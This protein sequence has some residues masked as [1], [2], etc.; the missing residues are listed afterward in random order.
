MIKYKIKLDND[1]LVELTAILKRSVDSLEPHPEEYM[2]INQSMKIVRS[3]LRDQVIPTF[4]RKL[5]SPTKVCSI[6]LK[7]FEAEAVSLAC[8]IEE[9][10]NFN[11]YTIALIQKIKN[12]KAA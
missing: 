2:T 1:E 3:L 9:T 10:N 7:E 5:I 11:P 8:Q 12:S 4:L 6:T